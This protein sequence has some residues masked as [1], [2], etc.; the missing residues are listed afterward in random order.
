MVNTTGVRFVLSQMTLSDTA[1]TN[2]TSLG[3]PIVSI[4]VE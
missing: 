1:Y 4:E 2:R 3:K